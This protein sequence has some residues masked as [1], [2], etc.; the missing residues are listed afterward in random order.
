MVAVYH[1]GKVAVAVAVAVAFVVD[2]LSTIMAEATIKAL[3]KKPKRRRLI[4]EEGPVRDDRFIR[5]TTPR[6]PEPEPFIRALAAV[7][8]QTCCSH[9]PPRSRL[10]SW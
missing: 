2:T 6:P 5:A 1:H 9:G 10:A 7:P 4:I 8:A 3:K